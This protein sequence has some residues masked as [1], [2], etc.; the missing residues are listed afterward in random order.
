MKNPWWGEGERIIGV[1]CRSFLSGLL[2]VLLFA[3]S[4]PTMAATDVSS[5]FTSTSEDPKEAKNVT[6]IPHN[7]K[8]ALF[9]LHKPV[10]CCIFDYGDVD[11]VYGAAAAIELIIAAK[12]ALL[13]NEEPSPE[14][15]AELDELH[16]TPGGLEIS[17]EA[18]VEPTGS[19]SKLSKDAIGYQRYMNLEVVYGT[20][21][22]TAIVPPFDI[23]IPGAKLITKPGPGNAMFF[24]V[25]HLAKSKSQISLLDQETYPESTRQSFFNEFDAMQKKVEITQS[26]MD[27]QNKINALPE[28]FRDAA[29]QRREGDYYVTLLGQ[30][31][32]QMAMATNGYSLGVLTGACLVH[33]PTSMLGIAGN[34]LSFVGGLAERA[35]VLYSQYTNSENSNNT[36]DAAESA[37]KAQSLSDKAAA[38]SDMAQ[39]AEAATELINSAQAVANDLQSP[40]PFTILDAYKRI[41]DSCNQYPDYCPDVIK[42]PLD[43]MGSA[44]AQLKNDLMSSGPVSE[45]VQ[46]YDLIGSGTPDD[47][48]KPIPSGLQSTCAAAGDA[49]KKVKEWKDSATN[50]V[51]SIPDMLYNYVSDT[52]GQAGCSGEQPTQDEQNM[53]SQISEIYNDIKDKIKA[54]KQVM[55]QALGAV[56]DVMGFINNLRWYMD[57]MGFVMWHSLMSTIA[58]IDYY[59]GFTVD[60]VNPLVLPE[61]SPYDSEQASSMRDKVQEQDTI[62]KDIITSVADSHNIDDAARGVIG[63]NAHF[64]GVGTSGVQLKQYPTSNNLNVI[65]LDVPVGNL[66]PGDPN[67]NFLNLIF[68]SDEIG[69]TNATVKSRRIGACT[70]EYG[71]IRRLKTDTNSEKLSAATGD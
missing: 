1:D 4:A 51:K 58:T 5:K 38:L 62:K 2:F 49:I 20:D 71:Y 37:R 54:A 3:F 15:L 69:T 40:N 65:G 47:P 45:V 52:W 43:T 57:H 26:A 64:C 10:D 7:E 19:I 23:E 66:T 28:N 39:K 16:Y 61:G 12:D 13:N 24:T 9:V 27:I 18:L 59:D 21:D 22:C 68:N 46:C 60:Y 53:C 6:S 8:E 55:G 35:A 41:K 17:N 42:T 48:D 30:S 63:Y 33:N 14:L 32:P 36:S 50:F 44:S 56:A 25:A 29:T 70:D 34:V 31:N 67:S 11:L